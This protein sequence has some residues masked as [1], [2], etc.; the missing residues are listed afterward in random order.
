MEKFKVLTAKNGQQ[1]LEIATEV[2]PDIIISDILMPGMNG[3]ELTS[4]IKNNPKTNHIPIILLTAL[5]EHKHQIDSINRG[6]DFFLTK[7]VDESLLFARI[8]NIFNNRETLK[9]KY[10]GQV[11]TNISLSRSEVFIQE[12][13]KIVE[14]NLQNPSFEIENLAKE[15]NISRSSL[16]RKIK[17]L[18]NQSSSE[19]IR[20]IRLTSAIKLMNTGK[21]NMD[22]IG[23]FVGFNSTSYFIRSFKKKYGKTPKDFYNDLMKS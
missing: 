2:I 4:K 19:Y 10:D 9:N 3:L 16:H 17:S 8:D 6:A 22:E 18:T 21:F 23:V 14:Q 13:R 11:H 12:A 20:D 1:A 5:T 15:L 7:P